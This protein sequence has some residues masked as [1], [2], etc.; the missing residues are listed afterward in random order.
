[1]WSHTR[2]GGIITR[3]YRTREA[4]LLRKLGLS[5]AL[6]AARITIVQLFGTKRLKNAASP[7]TYGSV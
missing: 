6:P 7:E 3:G 4:N 5:L 2:Y 1:M